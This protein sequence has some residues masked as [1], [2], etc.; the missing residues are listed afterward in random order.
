MYTLNCTENHA[1]SY[2]IGRPAF[3]QGYNAM[4]SF[5]IE[6][7]T[8]PT[9]VAKGPGAVA[10]PVYST[11]K[12]SHHTIAEKEKANTL[13]ASDYKDPPTAAHSFYPQMKAESQCFSTEIANTLVNGTNPGHHNGVLQPND[14]EYI[15]RR[16][17]PSECAKLQGFPSWWCK[18]LENPEPTEAEIDE[19]EQIFENFRQAVNPKSKP[20]TRK[21][22]ER[23]L[24]N[25]HSDS[26]EYRLW[27]NG[28]CS[29]IAFFVL[30]G[31]VWAVNWEINREMST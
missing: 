29:S 23:F 11:S 2:G 8:A 31:I 16:L 12:N 19:W 3:N 28:V 1:V 5:Q 25:P 9:M 6:K 22:I 30:S 13:V 15:V 21:A 18:G 10:A 26:S 20:K 24:K 14:M 17:T 4:Y 7:E 27:E